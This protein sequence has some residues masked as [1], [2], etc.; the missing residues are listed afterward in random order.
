M[1]LTIVVGNSSVRLGAFDGENLRRRARLLIGAPLEENWPFDEHWRF[2]NILIATVNP[3]VSDTL[4]KRLRDEYPSPVLLARR[5]FPLPITI[6]CNE[7]ENVGTD[8]LLGAIAAYRLLRRE[9]IVVDFGTAVTVDAVSRTGSFIDGAIFPGANI[10][11][12]SLH[13]NTAQLP[14]VWLA[15]ASSPLGKSTREAIK[16]GL[17][18]GLAGAADRLISEIK[19]T[20]GGSPR[21]IATGG[22]IAILE[23]ALLKVDRIAPDLNL[24]GLR[25]AFEET[26]GAK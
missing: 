10:S 13:S 19:K 14:E 16:A 23:S 8:R 26:L 24:H 12:E 9:C 2:D 11:C 25:I 20:I 18:W 7:P 21:V 15:P 17:F 6:E 4:E 5:D 22:D 3:P 1:L